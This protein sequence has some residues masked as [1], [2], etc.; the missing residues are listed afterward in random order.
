MSEA[1]LQQKERGSLAALRLIAWLT[2]HGG[3]ALGRAL[4]HPI[5]AYFIV[6]SGA[7]RRASRDYWRRLTGRPARWRDVYAQYHT[8]AA[9]LL[10]RIDLIAGRFDRFDIRVS[11]GDD[12][13]R[14]LDEHRGCLLLGSHLG[15]FEMMRAVGVLGRGLPLNVVMHER[16]ASLIGQ[17]MRERAPAMRM[18][19]LE[20]GQPETMLR[21][22]E[23]LARGEAVALLADRATPGTPT[24]AATLLGAPVQLPE[25]PFR[26]ACLL[27]AP[28]FL[29]FGLCRGDRRYDIRFERLTLEATVA[30]DRKA[31]ASRLAE[32]YAQRLEAQ[33]R[34]APANWFNFYDFWSRR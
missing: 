12:V 11:G 32:R 1:W 16:N 31:A 29:F 25:G 13:Q 27:D 3:H 17:W 18:R 7:A 4:L 30:G 28:V 20:P 34:D 21:V 8:F 6:F 9:T 2:T 15:S 33:M 14:A 26:V 22:R 10:D 19:A 24:C 5:C 23:C